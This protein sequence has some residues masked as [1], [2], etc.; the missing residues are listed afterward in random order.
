[1]LYS[2]VYPS[3]AIEKNSNSVAIEKLIEFGMDV[4]KTDYNGC[5]ILHR[6]CQ[7]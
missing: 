3:V 7:N 5:N 1:M 4:K 2:T 6:L